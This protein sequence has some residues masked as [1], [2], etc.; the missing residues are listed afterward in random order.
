MRTYQ[1]DLKSGTTVRMPS[2]EVVKLVIRKNQIRATLILDERHPAH[3]AHPEF[4]GEVTTIAPP[5]STR[6]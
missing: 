1:V 6:S 4:D 5:I 2:G 3:P